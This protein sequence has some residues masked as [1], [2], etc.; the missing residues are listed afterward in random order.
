MPYPTYGVDQFATVPL[1]E[2]A[3]S[4]S[5]AYAPPT[6]VSMSQ[7][8]AATLRTVTGPLLV[9]TKIFFPGYAV[10]DPCY[11]MPLPGFTSLIGLRRR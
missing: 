11:A 2:T 7:C 1:M 3:V 4:E 5:V 9:W 8:P 6:P 10:P